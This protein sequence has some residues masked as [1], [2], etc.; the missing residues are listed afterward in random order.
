MAAV[1]LREIRDGEEGVLVE[2]ITLDEPLQQV[3]R[4]SELSSQ[5]GK[6]AA[7]MRRSGLI[8]SR[9]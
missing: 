6:T 5:A 9:H 2:D 3:P 7:F 4:H 1:G 8:G